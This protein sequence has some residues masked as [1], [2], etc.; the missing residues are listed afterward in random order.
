VLKLIPIAEDTENSNN[1]K[2]K[3]VY[4]GNIWKWNETR[5]FK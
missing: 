5:V 3:E 4:Y 2:R 1:E